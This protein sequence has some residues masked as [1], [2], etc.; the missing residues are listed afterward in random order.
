MNQDA[1]QSERAGF[2]LLELILVMVLVAMTLALVAPTLRGFGQRRLTEDAATQMLL[3]IRWAQDR[4]VVEARPFRFNVDVEARG[5]YL[6]AQTGGA[7]EAVRSD[8]G[9]RF[10]LPVGATVEWSEP[11]HGGTVEF[12]R[13]DPTGI[14]EPGRFRLVND[15]GTVFEL[16]SNSVSEPY[17]IALGEDVAP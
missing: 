1:R 7:F 11:Q 15:D 4:A 5:Y 3:L 12:I 17:R 10:A 13:I 8:Y 9:R 14:V 6:T 2:T 16:V